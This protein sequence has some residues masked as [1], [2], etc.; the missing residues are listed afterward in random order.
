M[1][2][3]P[4]RTKRRIER[5]TPS[6][7]ASPIPKRSRQ[8]SDQESAADPGPGDGGSP[9]T[10]RLL[11][12]SK[13]SS[14]RDG[15]SGPLPSR[16]ESMSGSS[17]RS[18]AK[19]GSGTSPGSK[20]PHRSQNCKPRPLKPKDIFTAKNPLRCATRVTQDGILCPADSRT[21]QCLIYAV[22]NVLAKDTE[23]FKVVTDNNL[24]EPARAIVT[25]LDTR[26]MTGAKGYTAV[27]I[28]W[29][30]NN[31]KKFGRIQGYEWQ[32][33]NGSEHRALLSDRFLDG[34]LILLGISP[35]TDEKEKAFR[36][37]SAVERRLDG[38]GR[39]AQETISAAVTEGVKHKRSHLTHAVGLRIEGGKRVL[40][41]TGN[42]VIKTC[43]AKDLIF[44]VEKVHAIHRLRIFL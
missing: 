5:F 9:E 25:Y 33:L 15:C 21:N 20:H 13:I 6:E 26:G 31:L 36:K 24:S 39:Q 32:R 1:T 35:A 17:R 16:V 38:C 14:V 8:T 42:R 7:A 19:L 23:V 10:E 37:V 11:G 28:T 2:T 40:F 29:Y 3:R 44:S 22:L 34:A 4:I 30:L 43:T 27:G 41:D 12:S 18:S